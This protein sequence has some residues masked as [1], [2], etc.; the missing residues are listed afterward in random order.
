MT[1]Q[2]KAPERIWL[3]L[4]ESTEDGLAWVARA[5]E[6]DWDQCFIRADLAA[7]Q[8]KQAYERAARLLDDYVKRYF[9]ADDA[10]I[11]ALANAIRA[12]KSDDTPSPGRV[13]SSVDPATIVPAPDAVARLVDAARAFA[14]W[15][16][17]WPGNINLEAACRDIRAALA[18]METSH[19]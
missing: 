10:D 13:V 14:S 2:T 9:R 16:H 12:L 4:S 11:E 19:D 6:N 18:A 5:H 1:D 17:C 7:E 8:V 3:C 15:D